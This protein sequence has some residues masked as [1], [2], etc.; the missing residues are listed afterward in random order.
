MELAGGSES[1][2]HYGWTAGLG[3]EV[4][5]SGNWSAKAEYLF[6][7]LAEKCYLLTNGGHGFDSSALRLGVNYRF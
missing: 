2:V 1:N 7:G 6:I 4:G 5:I 3:L